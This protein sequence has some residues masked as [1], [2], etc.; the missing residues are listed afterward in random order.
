MDYLHDVDAF[1]AHVLVQARHFVSTG[2]VPHELVKGIAAINM[3]LASREFSNEVLGRLVR[4]LHVAMI[5]LESS[6]S[7]LPAMRRE[8]V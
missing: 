7:A 4:L 6:L 3:V 1:Q 5:V 8:N 2:I